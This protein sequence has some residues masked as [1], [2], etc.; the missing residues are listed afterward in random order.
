MRSNKQGI[1]IV[2]LSALCFAWIASISLATV[3]AEQL[4]IKVYTTSHGLA[5][6]QVTRILTD[7][8]GFLWFC[9]V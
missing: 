6:D 3:E 9:T 5:R 8:R 2:P 1:I 4:P 7:S